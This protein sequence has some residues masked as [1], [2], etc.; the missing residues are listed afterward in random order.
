[1]SKSSWYFE[2]KAKCKKPIKDYVKAKRKLVRILKK[3]YCTKDFLME[4][5]I[6]YNVFRGFLRACKE[7]RLPY[8]IVSLP[9]SYNRS[10]Y[11]YKIEEKV[12]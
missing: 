4:R 3:G 6:S 11:Y 2:A 7:G 12:K 5:G 1:M 8:K 10:I 9:Y